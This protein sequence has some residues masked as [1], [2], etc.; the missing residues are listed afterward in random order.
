MKKIIF[1]VIFVFL[2]IFISINYKYIFYNYYN[3]KWNI[4]YNNNNFSW[5]FKNHSESLSYFLWAQILYN[6]WN[7]YHKIW[8]IELLD[9]SKLEFYKKSEK[10]YLD[11][12]DELD[13]IKKQIDSNNLT[14]S[15]PAINLAKWLSNIPIIYYPHGLQPVATR[16]KSSLQENA[17]THVITEDIIE[18]C[19]NGIVAWE[20]SSNVQPILLQGQDDFIKTKERFTIIKEYF[21]KNNIEFKEI[22]SVSGNILTKTVCLTYLL[23]YVTI[24]FAILSKIDPSPVNSIDFIKERL[25]KYQKFILYRV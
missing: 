22:F 18:S 4:F 1:P 19:H 3:I 24:Y 6:I 8:D 13:R 12:L 23:D 11:S 14:D 2:I 5:A 21:N 20:N 9:K 17:K 25:W 10:K 15:N 7:D 16:F